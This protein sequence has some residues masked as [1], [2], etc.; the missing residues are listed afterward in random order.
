MEGRV[1]VP[2][3]DIEADLSFLVDTGADSSLIGPADGFEMGLD[4][5]AL[6]DLRE[7]LGTGGLAQSYMEKASIAFTDPTNAIYVYHVD[8]EIAVPHHEIE[9]MPSLLGR[10]ILDR[11]RMVYDPSKAELSFIVRSADIVLPLR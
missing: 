9:E 2:R 7:S 11:W 5:G 6:G 1:V 4:Y 3:F 8:L 10:E